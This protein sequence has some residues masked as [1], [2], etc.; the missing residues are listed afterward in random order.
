MQKQ[1][2]NVPLINSLL[3]Q[4]H[5]KAPLNITKAALSTLLNRINALP[6]LAH[7][8]TAFTSDEQPCH[9]GRSGFHVPLTHGNNAREL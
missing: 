4:L 5:T 1:L 6:K 7:I 2:L 3:D 8:L 9:E